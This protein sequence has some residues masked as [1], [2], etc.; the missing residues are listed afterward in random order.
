M[1]EAR[2]ITRRPLARRLAIGV[3]VLAAFA[4]AA[5]TTCSSFTDLDLNS[6]RF[7][8][9]SSI[10]PIPLPDR[11]AETPVSAAASPSAEPRWTACFGVQRSFLGT[12]RI[13]CAGGHAAAAVNGLSNAFGVAEPPPE[14]ARRLAD[15]LLGALRGDL[16]ADVE[17]DEQH[18]AVISN[19]AEVAR[20]DRK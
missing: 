9:R 10:G 13:D 20:W 16:R 17:F 2:A 11:T 3:G 12:A 18:I 4:A 19:G 14:E 7:R 15:A 5:T 6:G 1:S 8:S